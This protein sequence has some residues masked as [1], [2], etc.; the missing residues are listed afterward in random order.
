[1][2]TEPDAASDAPSNAPLERL[3]RSSRG[4]DEAPEHLILRAIDL[5]QPRPQAA[6][7]ST[8]GAA[9]VL[10]R[11]VAALVFDSGASTPDALGLRSGALATRQLLFTAEGHDVDLRLEPMAGGVWKLSGQ[12]LGP[13][14]SGTAELRPAGAPAQLV[15]WSAQ[16]EFDFEPVAT[17]A[18]QLLLRGDGWEIDIPDVPL[19]P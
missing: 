1:M 2:A 16:A 7:P 18:C 11:F 12:L 3:L 14:S 8:A 5:W 10:R 15:H 4:L 19:S 13:D 6:A 9:A 17:R